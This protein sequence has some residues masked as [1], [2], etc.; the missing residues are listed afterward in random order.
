MLV[1]L[2]NVVFLTEIDQI[3]DRLGS[4]EEEWVDELDL[5]ISSVTGVK[6]F[7]EQNSKFQN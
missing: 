7:P 3:D 6:Y 4:Q 2:S 5:E 1:L